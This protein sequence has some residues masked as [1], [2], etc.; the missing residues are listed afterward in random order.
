MR[1]VNAIDAPESESFFAGLLAAA[2]IE[3]PDDWRER[4]TV[5]ADRKRSRTACENLKLPDGIIFPS[6]L[7]KT[8]RRLVD[9]HAPGLRTLL[10]YA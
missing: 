2:G 3:R 5:G 10:G 1:E 4:V 8:Q 6:T 9:Y 7:P